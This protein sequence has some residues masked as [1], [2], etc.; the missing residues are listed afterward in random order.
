MHSQLQL[1]E[2]SFIAKDLLIQKQNEESPVVNV[3]TATLGTIYTPH[4]LTIEWSQGIWKTPI[5]KPF[6]DLSLSPGASCL[7]YAVEVSKIR[8]IS[9]ALK[10]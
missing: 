7:H 10:E 2:E 6:Q 4:M 3:E 5:I 8:I 1:N 9:S